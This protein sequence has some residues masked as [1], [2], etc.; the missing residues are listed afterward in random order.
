MIHPIQHQNKD[1]V[2][3]NTSTKTGADQECYDN[4]SDAT[5]SRKTPETSHSGEKEMFSP[6]H[7]YNIFDK[8]VLNTGD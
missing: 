7:S 6:L 4:N 1:A 5:N 2:Q 8:I 3:E